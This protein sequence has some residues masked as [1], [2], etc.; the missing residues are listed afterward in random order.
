MRV[1]SIAGLTCRFVGGVDGDGGGDGPVVVLLHGFGAPGDDLV[2]LWKFLA[3]DRPELRFVFPAAPLELPMFFGESRAWWMIDTERLERELAGGVERDLSAE[4]PDGLAEARGLIDSVLATLV[5]DHGA[6]P[7]RLVLGGFSQGAML[8]TEVTLRASVDYAGLV[9][10]SG[11]YLCAD[12][13]APLIDA[14]AVPVFQSHGRGDALLPFAQAERLRDRFAAAG[15]DHDWVA[16]D[17]G[18]E[19]PM[20]AAEGARRLIHRVLS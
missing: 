14:R 15:A 18:H 12:Q 11:T 7:E 19:I 16:F 13:W 8:S 1:E 4:T 20:A 3:A 2:A 5:V 6:S 9:I 10:W 17:G